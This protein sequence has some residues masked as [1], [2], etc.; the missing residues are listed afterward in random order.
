[1]HLLV[2][3]LRI[4]WKGE[5]KV[6]CQLENVELSGNKVD[7]G[8]SSSVLGCHYGVKESTVCFTKKN[9]DKIRRSVTASAPKCK[10]F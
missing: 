4:K 3:S 2:K 5:R 1:M 8:M 6:V 10:N 9:E 7:R